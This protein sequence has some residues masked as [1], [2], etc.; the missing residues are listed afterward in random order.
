MTTENHDAQGGHSPLTPPPPAEP[1]VSAAFGPTPPPER[2]GRSAGTTA[3]LVV[4]AVVGSI[5]LL[6]AGGTAAAAAVGNIVSSSS[7]DTVQKVDVDGIEGIEL[8]ADASTVRVEF[9]DVDEAQ[10]AVSNGRGTAWTFEREDDELVVSS[11]HGVFGWWF[12]NWF[13]DGEVAVLTLPESLRGTGLNADLTL[14]AGSL[15]VD[16]EFS[17]L[18]IDVNAGELRLN[19][20]ADEFDLQ[21]SAGTAT[22]ELDSVTE[23]DLGISAGDMNVRLTGTAPVR[24][25]VDASAGSVDLVLPDVA[26]SISDQV[27]AGSLDAV[28]D[29]QSGARNTIDVTLSAGSV[30]IRPGS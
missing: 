26:Y 16:G 17:G 8:D 10:L 27:S 29:Q 14:N 1:N 4:T 21:M 18:D 15:E 22:V 3:I 7:P 25:A 12:G 5:A 11:P 30:T 13:G 20:A 6:G 24:T 9:G 23:A 28:V 2:P 19:G